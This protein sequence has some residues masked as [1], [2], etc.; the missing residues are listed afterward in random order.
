MTNIHTI[1]IIL[2]C[3]NINNSNYNN[4][5]WFIGEKTAFFSDIVQHISCNWHWPMFVLCY[6]LLNILYF[7]AI[8]LFIAFSMWA[9]DHWKF[10]PFS[11]C[12][13]NYCTAWFVALASPIGVQKKVD[14]FS[15]YLRWVNFKSILDCHGSPLCNR[16]ESTRKHRCTTTIFECFTW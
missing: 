2:I 10:N 1:L 13:R 12:W 9:K 5:Y 14:C 16:T 15:S 7:I 8:L 3:I 6:N 4:M 11:D